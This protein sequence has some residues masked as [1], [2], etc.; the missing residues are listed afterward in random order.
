M[1]DPRT[2]STGE[3]T[4]ILQRAAGG[5]REAIDE[6]FPIVYRELRNVAARYM[7]QE[8]GG[9]TLQAT[10]LTHE[11]YLRLLGSGIPDV[12]DRAHF[13]AIAARAMRQILVERA[14]ARKR[15]KRGG[16]MQRVTFVPEL[17][18]GAEPAGVPELDILGLEDALQKLSASYAR[19][20]RVVELLYFGGMTSGEAALVLAVTRR[21]VE[22]DWQFARLWLLRE[23]LPAG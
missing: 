5:E 22:R 6:L 17:V 1:S 16:E 7:N 13:L 15:K 9:R 20:A 23:M 4:R 14:R 12:A 2:E 11:A 19:K 21:T 10:A 3:I 8:H 18:G